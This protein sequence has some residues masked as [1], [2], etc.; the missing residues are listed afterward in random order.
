MQFTHFRGWNFEIS[1][2]RFSKKHFNH[3]WLGQV[4]ENWRKFEKVG[5]TWRKLEPKET[6]RNTRKSS[7][8]Q[9]ILGNPRK[10]PKPW[11]IPGNPKKPREKSNLFIFAAGSSKNA[12][13]VFSQLEFP[14][15]RFT[16][17]RSWNFQ[18]IHFTHFRGWNFQK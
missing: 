13:Y 16:H 12:V 4:E 10:S 9:E 17:F 8:T 14:K 18:E 7:E 6:T 2:L 1:S 3:S 5:T 15:I 11:E